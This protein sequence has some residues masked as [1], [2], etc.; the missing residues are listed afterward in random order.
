MLSIPSARS[1]AG[2][3]SFRPCWYWMPIRLQPKS[4]AIRRAAM[5]ILHWVR[6]WSSVRS[7]SG[8]GPVTK[9]MPRSSI[10]LRT[11]RAS[12]AAVCVVS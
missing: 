9:V 8:F 3:R 6:I 5:Y 7:V 11:A 2:K 4:S 10:Q 1:L 12:S